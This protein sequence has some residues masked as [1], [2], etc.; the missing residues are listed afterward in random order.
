VVPERQR[1]RRS[2]PVAGERGER[3]CACACGWGV[4]VCGG[5]GRTWLADCSS[6]LWSSTAL[7]RVDHER[8]VRGSACRPPTRNAGRGKQRRPP[9]ANRRVP[10]AWGCVWT[11]PSHPVRRD[12]P[13]AHVRMLCTRTQTHART[14]AHKLKDTDTDKQKHRHTHTCAGGL[15][16]LARRAC[17]CTTGTLRL[18]DGG[19]GRR[20]PAPMRGR[21]ELNLG[22]D[23]AGVSPV[24]V[25][26]WRL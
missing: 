4:G 12:G 14:K 9:H 16:V 18:M 17:R 11:A 8:G 6:R 5:G 7:A 19:R 15:I 22:A 13:P 24:P 20:G 2:R 10:K 21:G 3:A 23:V 26:M 25:Q 1:Q